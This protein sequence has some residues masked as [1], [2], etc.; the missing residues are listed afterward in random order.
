MAAGVVAPEGSG[1]RI[2]VLWMSALGSVF[3]PAVWQDEDMQATPKFCGFCAAPLEPDSAV[4]RDCGAPV[5]RPAA[6]PAQASASAGS[7]R[8]SPAVKRPRFPATGPRRR[9]WGRWAAAGVVAALL[10]GGGA[11]A[12][13]LTRGS[14]GGQSDEV[15]P[16]LFETGTATATVTALPATETPAPTPTP[17]PTPSPTPAPRNVNGL[18]VVD[19]TWVGRVVEPGGL[20]IRSA[21]RV[22]AGNVVGS[23]AQGTDVTVEGRVLNGQEAEPGRGTVW[24]IVGPSQYIYAPEG[25][26]ERL[27]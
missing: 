6:A 17:P 11:T 21:P 9:R 22:D 18:M 5:A 23:I 27:R 2:F 7:A 8:P 25:Y 13:L 16:A 19:E 1:T 26:V 3:A 24:L 12:F 10:I 15:V 4:C 14:D 20:R